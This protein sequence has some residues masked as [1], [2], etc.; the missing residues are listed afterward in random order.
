LTFRIAFV[1]PSLA[2]G[3]AERVALRV[4]GGLDRARF[5]PFLVVFEARGPLTEALPDGLPVIDLE[6]PRLRR[7]L[8]R[9]IGTLR[10]EAPDTVFSTIGYVSIG[11][12]AAR[13]CLP[14]GTRIVAR[15]ANM[16][17]IALP[18][19]EYGWILR[20]GYRRFYRRADALICTSEQMTDEFADAFGVP[21]DRLA[22]IANPIDVA[23]LRRAGSVPVRAPG[24]GAR[25]VAAGRM[26]RQKGF[27]RLLDMFA[28]LPNSARLAILGEGEERA[29]LGARIE[30][31]GIAG[32]VELPGFEVRPWGRFAGADAFVMASRW[33][34]MPNAA[35]EALACGTPV[36][37]TPESGAIAEVAAA[38]PPGAVT[39]AP[40]GDAFV[41]AMRRVRPT[42]A[43]R[44]SL[45]PEKF[46]AE[47]V[48]EAFA[49]V[50]AG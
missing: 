10:S 15:E 36:I 35:L 32:R 47:R 17:S 6:R 23:A 16:P 29:A 46:R 22:T 9:L 38:A 41:A 34:G 42:K 30:R 44:A 28:R 45:L 50:L 37:A 14:R 49:E 43:P 12:L 20:H 3:G 13:R 2:G 24:R 8:P 25:F 27:D 26:R 21:R 48:V 5:E 40:A 39:I 31:L 19:V 7:A 18:R 4:A 11:L 1:L 33:E